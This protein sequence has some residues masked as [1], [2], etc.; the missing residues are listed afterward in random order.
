MRSKQLT[1][2][3]TRT[4]IVVFQTGD[5]PVEG[6]LRYVQR[7]HITGA[8]ITAIGAFSEV[9]L[10]Y[11]DLDRKAYEPITIA[12][13]VEVLSLSGD[14]ATYRSDPRVHAH[15]VVGKRDGTAHGGALLAAKVRPTLEVVLSEVPGHLEREIDPRTGLALVRP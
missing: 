12:E 10:G 6:L 3:E 15:V 14:V 7:E 11:F 13:Q 5:D 2:H 1:G 8:T 4:H 9:V